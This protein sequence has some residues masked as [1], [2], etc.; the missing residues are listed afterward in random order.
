M[1]TLATLF[2]SA[3][4]ALPSHTIP[5]AAEEAPETAPPTAAAEPGSD[6][7]ERRNLAGPDAVENQLKTD[8]KPKVP[9]FR[10]DGLQRFLA[11]YFD[12]KKQLAEDHGFS[13]G[14]DYTGAY[15]K[16]SESPG[17]DEAGS[18]IFR[19]FGAWELTGRGTGSTG[20]FVYK[21]EHRHRY[22]SVPPKGLALETGYTGFWLPPFSNDE[23]RLTN[24]YWHQ[25]FAEGRGNVLVGFLDVTDYLD[26]Y[27]LASPWLHFMNLVFSTGSASIALPGDATF[28]A[29]GG[30]FVTD[31]FYFSVGATDSNADPTDPFEGVN[32]FFNDN[33]YFSHVEL[34]WASSFDRR[35]AD[36]VH[37]TYWHVDARQQAN[38]PEGWGINGSATTFLDDR[39][40]PFLRGGYAEDGGSLLS[41][42]VSAGVGYDV[43]ERDDVVG[44]GLN[45][46]RPN[47]DT[48]T[49]GLPDQ[50]TAELFYRFQFSPNFAV[51]P[52]LQYVID[53]A[54][55]PAASSMWVLGLRA[56]LAL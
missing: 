30:G 10:F 41:T 50:Y 32:S 12:F 48:F 21:V 35:Y 44:L 1:R 46:G 42:S 29:V 7:Q 37:L 15:L 27:A 24:L 28:G 5:G 36:N 20:T 34:G 16:A 31:N 54:L 26:V 38:T 11:P 39:W 51:T 47:A 2:T 14:L 9:V 23:W 43:W 45:W 56:R 8:A 53:P 19:F 6:E 4:L 18:G 40:M 25:R 52:D 33:E 49:T 17:E 3:L 13:F 22:T 55:N